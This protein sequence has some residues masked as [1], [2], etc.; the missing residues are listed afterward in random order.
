MPC[1]VVDG[2]DIAIPCMGCIGPGCACIAAVNVGMSC[3]GAV[4]EAAGIPCGAA[5]GL[6]WFC[7]AAGN[8][9]MPCAGIV[10]GSIGIP[11]VGIVGAGFST[12]NG[13]R[14]IDCVE[15]PGGL[16]AESAGGIAGAPGCKVLGCMPGS[17]GN[18]GSMAERL[19]PD[20]NK[21]ASAAGIAGGALEEA[22]APA[23]CKSGC[24]GCM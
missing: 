24:C 19:V 1:V 6:G 5:V 11:C 21:P 15:S 3:V 22:L 18:G 13:G 12:P 4:C 23:I 16:N 10:G 2:E 20:C 17:T 7:D 14:E 9:D 8:I